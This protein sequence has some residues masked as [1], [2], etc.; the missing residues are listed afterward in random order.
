MGLSKPGGNPEANKVIVFSVELNDVGG[1][2]SSVRSRILLAHSYFLP[3]RKLLRSLTAA[4][5]RGVSVTLLVPGRSDVPLARWTTALLY[6]RLLS[7][8]V[9]VYEWTNS[10]LHAKLAVVDGKRLLVGSF[11]L[12]PYSL[13]N[14]EALVES[15]DLEAARSAE[16]WIL[17]RVRSARQITVAD[18]PLRWLERVLG[19]LGRALASWIYWLL[20]R[21]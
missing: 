9:Q 11:N 4:A 15:H 18:R 5:R 17:R 13:A 16:D 20:A 21:R 10:V 7:A 2:V 14:L 1:L 3:D 12:D 8:G 6:R 19:H